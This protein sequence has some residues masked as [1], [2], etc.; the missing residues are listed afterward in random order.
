[1]ILSL[2]EPQVSFFRLDLPICFRVGEDVKVALIFIE[3]LFAISEGF[4]KG[5]M[6]ICL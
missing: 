3:V 4:E 2:V 1:M 6:G 5:R